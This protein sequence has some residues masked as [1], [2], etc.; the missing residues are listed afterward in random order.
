MSVKGLVNLRKESVSN[1]LHDFGF[2]AI[3][4]SGLFQRYRKAKTEEDRV[5]CRKEC[6]EYEAKQKAIIREL[7]RRIREAKKKI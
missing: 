4:I 7:N 6:E 1:L 5:K 3:L 2:V